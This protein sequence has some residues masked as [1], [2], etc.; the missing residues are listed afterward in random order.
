MENVGRWVKA[1]GRSADETAAYL[2]A[3]PTL[4]EGLAALGI[5][6]DGLTP[7][8]VLQ[9]V[10]ADQIENRFVPPQIWMDEA[11]REDSSLVYV[12][13]VVNC[14]LLTAVDGST[15]DACS[16]G[17]GGSTMFTEGASDTSTYP[18]YALKNAGQR[19]HRRFDVIGPEAFGPDS[20][21]SVRVTHADV[22]DTVYLM[23]V[24]SNWEGHETE[25][26]VYGDFNSWCD[27]R[28]TEGQSCA[29]QYGIL[30]KPQA[31]GGADDATFTWRLGDVCQFND[32]GKALCPVG[33]FDESGNLVE[34]ELELDTW[35]NGG[36]TTVTFVD[37]GA[38]SSAE[39]PNCS[40]CTAGG[41]Q[42]NQWSVT[43]M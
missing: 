13:T 11:D 12:G 4:A 43:L 30:L 31:S 8:A 15:D 40:E 3:D 6:S 19:T 16:G 36:H 25:L 18:H 28:H 27:A 41:G 22:Q 23:H 34:G 38:D 5:A 21:V 26:M 1:Y 39:L 7:M 2:E 20:T 24:P 10:E 32:A 29:P 35:A 42:V 14:E 37:L 9:A 33:G 17:G